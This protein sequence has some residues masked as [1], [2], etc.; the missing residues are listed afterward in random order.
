VLK[1]GRESLWNSTR[2]VRGQKR[3]IGKTVC[4]ICGI[5]G[6]DE[7]DR[8]ESMVLNMHHRGPDDSGVHREP[9]I[10]LGM[11]RLAIIDLSPKAH[12]PMG[13]A[14]STVWI[15][16]NGET[17]NFQ[18][19]R[20][21]LINKGYSFKSTS[22][23]EVVLKMYEEYGD[24][25]LLRIRGMFALAIYDKRRGPGKERLLL[26]R[27]QLGIKPLL[28]AKA[29]ST[30]LFASELKAILTHKEYHKEPDYIAIHHYLIPLFRILLKFII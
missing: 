10:A 6:N 3:S 8:V 2:K 23:T 1:P 17:Y 28:Y 27:D 26:A 29:G 9:G 15:V 30:F 5:L 7:V 24:D 14:E 22:D 11:A 21:A 25:F 4:G 20:Q 18:E 16:Y 19:E 12:Q 13:N